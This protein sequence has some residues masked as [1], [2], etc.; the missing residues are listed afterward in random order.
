M[1]FSPSTIK[2]LYDYIDSELSRANYIQFHRH[3][4]WEDGTIFLEKKQLSNSCIID[5]LML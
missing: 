1:K 3:D 4:I 5:N 2:W